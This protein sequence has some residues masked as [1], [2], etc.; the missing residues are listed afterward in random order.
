MNDKINT[1][2][3]EVQSTDHNVPTGWVCPICKRVYA[4]FTTMCPYCGGNSSRDFVAVA[5]TS[6]YVT[7]VTTNTTDTPTQ[8]IC[9]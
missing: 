6:E 3:M 9:S 5:T 8:I 4:P 7:T 1:E 2:I